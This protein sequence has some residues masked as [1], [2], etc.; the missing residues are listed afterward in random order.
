MWPIVVPPVYAKQALR[1]SAIQQIWSDARGALESADRIVVF[2]YSLPTLDV[3]AEKVFERSLSAN[4][5][6]PWVD[7]I[8]PAASSAARFAGV[9]A[10]RPVRWYPSLDL[11]FGAGALAK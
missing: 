1:S 6:A 10:G 3:E 5:D 11:F 9:S 8:N 7:V 2:G 4:S